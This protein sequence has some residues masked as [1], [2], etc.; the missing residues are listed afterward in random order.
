MLIINR[1]G[2]SD[3]VVNKSKF[4]GYTVKVESKNEFVSRLEYIKNKNSSASHVA[5]AYKIK[6][7]KNNNVETNFYDAGEPSGTAGKPILNILETRGIINS[8]IMVVRYYGGVNLGT[9]GLSRAYAKTAILA[10][11]CSSLI[12]YIEFFKYK[13][14]FKYNMLDIISNVIYKNNGVIIDDM[15]SK[16]INEM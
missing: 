10:L 14:I 11:S 16:E 12:K 13:L 4:F 9:G 5:F 7:F 3:L 2:E 15:K 6:N 8:A 1:E